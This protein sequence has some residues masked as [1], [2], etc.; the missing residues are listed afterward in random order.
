MKPY[1]LF[2][3]FWSFVFISCAVKNSDTAK[4]TNDISTSSSNTSTPHHYLLQ[5]D[6][7]VGDIPVFNTY[8]GIAPIFEQNNDTTYVIN[9]WA[10]WCKPCVEEL[11]YFEKVH[12]LYQNKKLKVVL[13][14]LDFKKQLESKLLPFVKE[15]QLQPEVLALTDGKYNTWIDKVDAEWGGAIPI[16]VIYNAQKRQFVEEPFANFEELDELIQSLMF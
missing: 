9:F 8:E 5:P 10:T 13:V 14:S 4:N 1:W 3:I 6:S 2:Y 7:W 16:T 15:R 11:P 12:Q